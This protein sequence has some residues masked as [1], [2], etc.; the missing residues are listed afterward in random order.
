M[1]ALRHTL[2][3]DAPDS[4]PSDDTAAPAAW[5]GHDIVRSEAHRLIRVCIWRILTLNFHA[6]RCIAI[7]GLRTLLI[8]P[9]ALY[10]L[11]PRLRQ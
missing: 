5:S 7:P 11:L 9:L 3:Y 2:K 6:V 4:Q 8:L 1:R 10:H